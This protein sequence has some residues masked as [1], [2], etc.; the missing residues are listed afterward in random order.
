MGQPDIKL[1]FYPARGV[2]E[3]SPHSLLFFPEWV[4]SCMQSTL[5]NPAI[6][7]STVSSDPFIHCSPGFA[8]AC[9]FAPQGTCQKLL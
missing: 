9:G 5:T 8:L 2:Q 7:T 1:P 3:L 6:H 4:A